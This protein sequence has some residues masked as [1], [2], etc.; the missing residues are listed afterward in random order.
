MKNNL[1]NS[2]TIE[3]HPVGT[4]SNFR[5]EVAD[6]NWG[7]VISCI[8]L[9]S[10]KFTSE[11]L[12][13]LE[14]FSHAEIIFFMNQVQL[15]KIELSSRHPRNNL[16]WPKI[17]I[18]SQRGKNRPNQIGITNVKIIEVRDTELV[19][20]GL[21][22]IDGTPVLDIK[23]FYSEFAPQEEIHQPDWSRD[24]MKNYFYQSN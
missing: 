3:L 2:N 1:N 20:K 24:I 9:D 23:P 22:A 11:A 13:G 17:G 15:D 19:V 10:S 12:R 6:D 14:D 4:V 8:K 21:D 16:N 18:F 7:E 5:K